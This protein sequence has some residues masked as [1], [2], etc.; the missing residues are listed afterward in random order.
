MRKLKNNELE[1]I[2]IKQFKAAK[3]TPIILILDNIRSALNVGSIFR[4]ADAF[5]IKKII[6]CGITA[7]P[8][9]KEIQKAALGST[10]TV[11]WV[12]TSETLKT[13]KDLKE[14]GYHIIAVEQTEDS[15]YLQSTE[16]H[17]KPI[18]LI[19]GNEVKG[20]SQQVINISNQIIE[21][22]QFGTKH[23]LNISVSAGIVI[24]EMWKNLQV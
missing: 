17:E 18:A 23:S 22:P 14:K 5:L 15:T 3:K 21:I 8:P 9:N 2:S 7:C 16:K 1:R 19:F 4:T 10:E 6:L 11:D 24:W 12:K 20:V 13:V